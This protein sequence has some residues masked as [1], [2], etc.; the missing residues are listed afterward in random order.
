[1]VSTAPSGRATG[2]ASF[3]HRRLV[4]RLVLRARRRGPPEY[5]GRLAV[6]G[7][8]QRAVSEVLTNAGDLGGVRLP[9]AQNEALLRTN[10]TIFARSITPRSIDDLPAAN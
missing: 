1:M 5:L 8:D 10:W 6:N 2:H 4:E 3:A 9:G 7:P